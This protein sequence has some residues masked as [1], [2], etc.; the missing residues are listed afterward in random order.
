M[1]IK[2]SKFIQIYANLSKFE[3]YIGKIMLGIFFIFRR[4]NVTLLEIKL[5]GSIAEKGSGIL[6]Q[7]IEN[8]EIV[9][10]MISGV[11]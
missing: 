10:F 9:N 6:L 1:K 2:K 11:G 8:V 7:N 5:K 4:E 3:L